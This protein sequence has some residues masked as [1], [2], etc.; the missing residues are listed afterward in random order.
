MAMPELSTSTSNHEKPKVPVSLVHEYE[1]FNEQ[2]IPGLPA[3]KGL[4]FKQCVLFDD[5]LKTVIAQR[6][7]QLAGHQNII[8]REPAIAE[9]GEDL[10]LQASHDDLQRREELAMVDQHI[11]AADLGIAEKPFLFELSVHSEI[12]PAQNWH[13]FVNP[14]STYQFDSDEPLSEATLLDKAERTLRNLRLNFG[15]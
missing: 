8:L 5:E 10:D 3:K 4:D 13:L 6:N 7:F 15:R 14:D 9:R 1:A 11:K 2:F 12:D